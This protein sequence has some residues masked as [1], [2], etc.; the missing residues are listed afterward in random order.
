[1]HKNNIF[2]DTP[3]DCSTVKLC[4]REEGM[5]PSLDLGLNIHTLHTG[6]IL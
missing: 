5:E 3:Q 4:F 2:I 6:S 1:M